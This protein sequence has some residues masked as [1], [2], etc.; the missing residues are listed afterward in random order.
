MP[1]AKWCWRL[2]LLSPRRTRSST[3]ANTQVQP[4][5]GP[6]RTS[7]RGSRASRGRS[8]SRRGRASRSRG[9]SRKSEANSSQLDSSSSDSHNS[10]TDEP[11]QQRPSI[12]FQDTKR[13]IGSLMTYAT[14]SGITCHHLANG[15]AN[16]PRRLARVRQDCNATNAT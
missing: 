10:E 1:G 6:S 9:V 12:S 13:A 5:A 7:S 8:S 14:M 2:G 11:Q 4:V 15:V 3:R 16:V